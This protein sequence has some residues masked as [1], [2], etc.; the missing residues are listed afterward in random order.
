MCITDLQIV[1][2]SISQ[3][4]IVKLQLSVMPVLKG[5]IG[6]RLMD[7]IL[8]IV[9]R[10]CGKQQLNSMGLTLIILHFGNLTMLID[11]A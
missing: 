7:L 2:P 1:R 6:E 8:L 10:I 11:E 5:S 9:M 4:L 3:S